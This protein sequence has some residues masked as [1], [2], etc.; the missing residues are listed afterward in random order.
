[1]KILS[2][3]HPHKIEE[4]ELKET[5]IVVKQI[6]RIKLTKIFRDFYIKRKLV[7]FRA[8]VVSWPFVKGKIS[9]FRATVVLS[10]FVN[11]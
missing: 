6:N 11:G 9:F 10:P 4:I 7:D 3:F 1:M 5:K 2:Q 8:A